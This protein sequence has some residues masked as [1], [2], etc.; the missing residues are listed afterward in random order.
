MKIGHFT[1][2]LKLTR[3]R[4]MMIMAVRKCLVSRLDE[5]AWWLSDRSREGSD[6][7]IT[8]LCIMPFLYLLLQCV[9]T[10]SHY[11][12]PPH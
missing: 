2:P 1:G 6:R 4:M 10:I 8:V 3:G 9:H 7:A 11:Y 12:C 5:Q